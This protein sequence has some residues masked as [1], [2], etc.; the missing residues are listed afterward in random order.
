MRRLFIDVSMLRCAET[1]E[2]ADCQAS[3]WEVRKWFWPSDSRV[4]MCFKICCQYLL[5]LESV[6]CAT[7]F[8]EICPCT[9][10]LWSI[11]QSRPRWV[12]TTSR[13]LQNQNMA[14]KSVS[15]KQLKLKKKNGSKVLTSQSLRRACTS[16]AEQWDCFQVFGQ[17]STC[18]CFHLP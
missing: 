11:F 15:W 2:L 13:T 14:I 18:S 4:K 9:W 12:S 10:K 5:Y 7:S 17:R 1:S 3:Y 8:C 16:Q 6:F